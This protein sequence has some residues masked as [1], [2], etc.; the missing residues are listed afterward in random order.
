MLYH[1]SHLLLEWRGSKD[2]PTLYDFM[3]E[4]STTHASL[5]RS[6]SGTSVAG[7]GAQPFLLGLDAS[8]SA[9]PLYNAAPLA[10]QY[11]GSGERS[12][13]KSHMTCYK[14]WWHRRP[15]PPIITASTTPVCGGIQEQSITLGRKITGRNKPKATGAAEEFT[16]GL[17]FRIYFTECSFKIQQ[18]SFGTTGDISDLMGMFPI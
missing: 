12:N 15:S 14:S 11:G 18:W 4:Q 3:I 6:L 13:N 9:A 16:T 7:G 1:T 2:E 10:A 8:S 5:Q 17:C